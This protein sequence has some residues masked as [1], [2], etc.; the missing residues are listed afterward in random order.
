MT[1]TDAQRPANATTQTPASAPA[2]RAQR[3]AGS[4][5][6]GRTLRLGLSRVV[7]ETRGYF[8]AGD[9]VFF[10]FL[11][12]VVLLGIFSVAFQGLGNVG[13]NADGSGGISQAAYYLPGMI[14]AGILLSGVQNL[15]VDI[16]VERGD[17]TLKRLAGTPL[18][19]LSYF[20]G[21]MGQVLV[22]SAAQVVLL[23]LLARVAFGVELPS[24]PEHWLTLVWVYL[25]GISTAAVLG[26]A[27]SRLPQSGKS[28][29][30]VIIPPLLILQFIS[31]VYL[32]F[33]LLPDWLQNVASVF[34]LKW[35][36]QG[37][38]AALLPESFAS[39][40]QGGAWDP[41]L[42]AVVLGVWLVLGLI[43][44]RVTFRWIR[45]D[46]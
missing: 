40:E 23:L 26:I 43:V 42:V 45:K 44:C 22:T 10:T 25:L 9:T 34:P 1:G 31:G 11:F 24:D 21:K 8:R 41:H 12:P 20:I 14:A 32:Q 38:R 15:G 18:P 33:T 36:A 13:A 4:F 3:A 28:A 39:A 29:S 5:G 19:V 37:M 7:Y 17:G 16:A 30:A 35:I 2:T 46:S 27:V 6:L